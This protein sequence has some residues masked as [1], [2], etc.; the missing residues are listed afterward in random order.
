MQSHT[1]S[2]CSSPNNTT[3]NSGQTNASD[4]SPGLSLK[5]R[6]ST[7]LLAFCKECLKKR[8]YFSQDSLGKNPKEKN[9]QRLSD[10]TG[11]S[12]RNFGKHSP[13]S[14]EPP[15][16]FSVV[17]SNVSSHSGGSRLSHQISYADLIHKSNGRDTPDHY[18]DSNG[19]EGQ[20]ASDQ[21]Q[22]LQF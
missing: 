13:D 22:L 12:S 4:S 5:K 8:D 15:R 17:P 3:K 16:P 9:F 6:I 18:R 10:P 14:F 11:Y 1:Q 20:H 7:E 19:S 2:E 21:E